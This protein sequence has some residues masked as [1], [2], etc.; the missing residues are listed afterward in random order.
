MKKLKQYLKI[1]SVIAI[2]ITTPYLVYTSYKKIFSPCGYH[3]HLP[4]SLSSTAA[5]EIDNFIVKNSNYQHHKPAKIIN[6]IKEKF[7]F[8]KQS[9]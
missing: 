4:E 3:L 1:S 5:Q 9:V 6:D 8:I 7:P 2:G